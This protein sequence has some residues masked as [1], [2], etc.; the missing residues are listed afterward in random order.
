MLPFPEASPLLGL[1]W[2]TEY[3][4]GASSD[5]IGLVAPSLALSR[6]L[7]FSPASGS[8]KPLEGFR[9][10][11]PDLQLPSRVRSPWSRRLET[12]VSLAVFSPSAFF[13]NRA[14][15]PP[16]RDHLPGSVA[17]SAFLTLSRLFST[18]DLPA[19]FHAG[20]APGVPPFRVDLRSQSRS[21]SRMSLPSWGSRSGKASVS[22]IMVARG[23]GIPWH[24]CQSFRAGAF[25][26]RCPFRALLPV[27]VHVS[28]PIV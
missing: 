14:A 8:R 22:T 5:R 12:T 23:I 19:L 7:R 1:A 10:S 20:P 15:T 21:S 17:F 11:S 25:S 9:K 24:P 28:G 13:R 27:S 4:P 6:P 3:R 16:D 18:R 26:S 2:S